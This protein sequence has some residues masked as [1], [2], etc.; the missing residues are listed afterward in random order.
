MRVLKYKQTGEDGAYGKN[1]N[2]KIAYEERKRKWIVPRTPTFQ[3][4]PEEAVSYSHNV[5]TSHMSIEAIN[6]AQDPDT[7]ARK[8]GNLSA[9]QYDGNI[10]TSLNSGMLQSMF[11]GQP[12]NWP[13]TLIS[14]EA[15]PIIGAVGRNC[16]PNNALVTNRP[17]YE[18]Q[19]MLQLPYLK[20]YRSTA[21]A[22]GY[23]GS[24]ITHLQLDDAGQT[25]AEGSGTTYQPNNNMLRMS[26]LRRDDNFQG[27]AQTPFYESMWCSSVRFK[28]NFT[29]TMRGHSQYYHPSDANADAWTG[30]A[31]LPE[32]NML[33]IG[34]T[35]Y[36]GM[37]KHYN[38]QGA[39]SALDNM[40]YESNEY[41]AYSG[42][43]FKIDTNFDKN[44]LEAGAA[45][46]DDQFTPFPND[47]QEFWGNKIS[48]PTDAQKQ[49]IHSKEG[50]MFM[51]NYIIKGNTTFSDSITGTIVPHKFLGLTPLDADTLRYKDLAYA[52]QSDLTSLVG[53]N[54]RDATAGRLQ[55]AFLFPA[56]TSL[57]GAW[58]TVNGP[59]AVELA[60]SELWAKY[61]EKGNFVIGCVL[62]ASTKYMVPSGMHIYIDATISFDRT[63]HYFHHGKSP[64][65]YQPEKPDHPPRY[66][67][68]GWTIGDNTRANNAY[69]ED[70]V[71]KLWPDNQEP[72]FS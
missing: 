6:D 1:K 26:G 4:W 53:H 35:P 7:V 25:A 59:Q 3:M 30:K 43:R 12:M 40:N 32:S 5:I 51:K 55:S 58:D 28:V 41:V 10:Q 57:K 33:R 23:L 8:P 69:P 36:K 14:A 56:A 54:E 66:R 18:H 65:F 13:F 37:W 34:F 38:H 27:W 46:F 42:Q 9:W 16:G 45:S 50:P 62:Q 29:V 48:D 44:D 39:T 71:R 70:S 47:Y 67:M 22:D 2:K 31:Q 72:Y 61:K 64:Q 15:A 52:T 19:M 17:D 63:N 68:D 20:Q 49:E 21:A 11:V 24:Q 60:D